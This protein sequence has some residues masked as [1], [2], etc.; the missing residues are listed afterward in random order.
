[1]LLIRCPNCS[2]SHEVPRALLSAAPRK[3]RCASCRTIF[4]A[5]ESDSELFQAGSSPEVPP[6]GRDRPPVVTPSIPVGDDDLIG[7]DDAGMTDGGRMAV[8]DIDS[9]FD[10]PVTPAE[11]VGQDGID[12]LFAAPEPAASP[13]PKAPVSLDN[14]QDAAIAAAAAAVA[15]ATLAAGSVSAEEATPRKRSAAARGKPG[16]G[17]SRLRSTIGVVM[18]TGIGTLV[19]LAIFRHETVRLMPSLASTF[20]AVGLDVNATGLEIQEV[21]SRIIREDNHDTLEV[22]GQIVNIT[23][24]RQGIPL[25]RLSIHNAEGAQIYVWTANADRNELGAGEKTQFRRRLASPPKDGEQVMVRF[26]EKDD[27]VASIR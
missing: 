23:R 17:P 21:R 1:M 15:G 11:T 4:E 10:Q 14:A 8:D 27:I 3:M 7:A 19:A 6:T 5:S 9:L 18:A 22:V 13:P 12:D 16:K 2:S 20:E 24:A 26:V 25:M